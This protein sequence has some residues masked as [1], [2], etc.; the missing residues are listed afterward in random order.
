MA[1]RGR[2]PKKKEPV[3]SE[4]LLKGVEQHEEKAVVE[5][6]SEGETPH[7]MVT[8][9]LYENKIA[10]AEFTGTDKHKY[11]SGKDLIMVNRG[12]KQMR[13]NQRKEASLLASEARAEK[14]RLAKL[15]RK[16]DLTRKDSEQAAQ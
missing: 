15:E 3:T 4:D 11:F 14:Q 13:H 12:I 2:P 6:V 10:D 16:A 7:G 5:M 9:Y 8:I 1:K